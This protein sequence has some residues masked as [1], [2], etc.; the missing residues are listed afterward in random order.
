MLA[1][2]HSAQQEATRTLWRKETTMHQLSGTAGLVLLLTFAAY[3]AS[4][5]VN[6]GQAKD[7]P[8]YPPLPKAVSNPGA[9]VCDGWVYVYGGHTGQPHVYSREDILGTFH[10]LKL[11]G[12]TAWEELPGDVALLGPALVAHQGKLYRL[13]GTQARNRPGEENDL[14]SVTSC[15]VY[16]AAKR[17]WQALPDLP[18]GR[19][20]HD[21]VVLG[22][23]I[24][25][26]GG[27]RLQGKGE[28]PRWHDTAL[29]LDLDRPQAGWRTISQPFR[30]RAFAAAAYRGRV[31]VIGGLRPNEKMPTLAV[32]IYNPQ[33]NTW[34]TGPQMPGD[35]RNGFSPAC[36]V[37]G[38]QLYLSPADGK[39][40]RLADG[41][42][43]E[44]ARLTRPRFTHRLV[45]V[46][47]DKLLAIGGTSPKDQSKIA[48]V[49]LVSVK[50][51][52]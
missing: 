7:I 40:Y 16:D 45:A 21:A 46:D 33:T 47:S 34:S 39:T 48:E 5:G 27:W 13:G 23:R 29:V 3:L 8:E 26:V 44:V 51:S 20:S 6:V 4:V 52:R 38:D 43:Q 31:Y 32:H 35:A 49:E 10:R 18:D 2:I 37:A 24:Y 22:N 9:A 19:S 12:G 36:C 41:G 25:V 11:D 42:W 17:E 15:A 30:G 1:R 14:L 28:P 50:P